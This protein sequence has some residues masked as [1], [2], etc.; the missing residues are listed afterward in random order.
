MAIHEEYVSATDDD[1]SVVR[2]VARATLGPG[3]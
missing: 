2:D 1:E 3:H